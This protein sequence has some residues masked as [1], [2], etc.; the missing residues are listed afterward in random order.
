[1]N[2]RTFCKRFLFS[3][4][5]FLLVLVV[6]LAG[7]EIYAR[8]KHGQRIAVEIN[9]SVFRQADFQLHH[10]LIPNAR[11]FSIKKE[12]QV[13]YLINSFGFRDRD[14]TYEKPANTFR[15]L[16][17]GDSFTEGHGVEIEQTFAKIFEKKLNQ[18]P[19]QNIDYEVI[20]CGVGGY[21]PLLEYL[22]LSEKALQFK[23]DMVVICY[24]FTDLYDDYEYAKTT[25]FDK[26]GLP[27]KCIPYKRIRS[28]SSNPL[29]RFLIRHSR[30]YVYTES[31]INKKLF[32][33]RYGLKRGSELDGFFAVDKTSPSAAKK[34]WEEDGKLYELR[35][36]P[37]QDPE[38]DGFVAYREGQKQTAERFWEQ[39]KKYLGLSYEILK[40]QGIPLV[41]VSYPHAIEV[42][43]SEWVE[44]RL[45]RELEAGKIYQ[46]PKV[47]NRLG[48]FAEENQITF[49]NLYPY[50]KASDTHPLYYDFD[51]HFN[52]NG[53][54]LAAE[55]L[56]KSFLK[57]GLIN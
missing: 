20:N 46:Q 7:G 38:P 41:L 17:L 6:Y 13:P 33:M 26:D 57:T 56:L 29:E 3:L 16:V 22:L 35:Y 19:G 4:I 11:G 47:V 49:I 42:S 31:R 30:F 25:F 14:Y 2:I 37:K 55:G 27:L 40:K 51:G 45:L 28:Y 18:R 10:S 32:K 34:L 52:Q 48:Q 53:H 12:W 44:G 5:A 54:R 43:T 50:F 21:S 15:I 9:E 8:I 39:N 24:D 36:Q 1:M 23:P